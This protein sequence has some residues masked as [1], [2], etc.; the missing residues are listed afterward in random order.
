MQILETTEHDEAG[1]KNFLI[2]AINLTFSKVLDVRSFTFLQSRKGSIT[3][4]NN[5]NNHMLKT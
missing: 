1:C 4:V 2:F 3:F 5:N